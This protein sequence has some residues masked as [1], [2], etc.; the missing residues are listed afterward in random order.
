MKVTKE[1]V[2]SVIEALTEL[3]NNW[4]DDSM[5][6]DRGRSNDALC[7]LIWDDGSG[8]LGTQFGDMFNSQIEFDNS[9]EL[10]EALTSWLGYE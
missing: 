3:I 10:A 1:Q 8:K 5:D 4:N 6:E 7:L 2:E 9:E